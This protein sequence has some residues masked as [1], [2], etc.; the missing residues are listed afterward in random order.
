V[1]RAAAEQFAKKS[2]ATDRRVEEFL[3]NSFF[4]NK[5]AQRLKPPLIQLT[6]SLKRRPD[7]NREFTKL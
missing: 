2:R 4:G 5:V 3:R 6:A 7:T 1:F